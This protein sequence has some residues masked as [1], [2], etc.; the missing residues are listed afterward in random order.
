MNYID[1][2]TAHIKWKVRLSR[3]VDGVAVPGLD[4]ATAASDDR[5]DLGKWIRGDGARLQ[6]LAHYRELVEA[7][8][9]FHAAAAVVAKKAERGDTAGAWAAMHEPFAAA[10]KE[11]I[12]AI[13]KLKSAAGALGC[14]PEFC[15]A[16]A[17]CFTWRSPAG[18]RPRGAS[19]ARAAA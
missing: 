13:M 7:H 14:A 4:G 1:A 9:R 11:T 15:A 12:A 17:A 19:V 3:F 16:P 18:G 5:C 2:I 8:A 6:R 10:S